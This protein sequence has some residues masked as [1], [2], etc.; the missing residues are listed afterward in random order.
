MAHAV[1]EAPVRARRGR[2]RKAQRRRP[3]PIDDVV[4]LDIPRRVIATFAVN[5][6]IKD[7]PRLE[8][9]IIFEPDDGEE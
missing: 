5:V 1:Q 4:A 2:A 3:E 9:T 6:R 7:L 8:P